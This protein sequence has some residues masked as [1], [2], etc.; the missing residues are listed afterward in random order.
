MKYKVGDRV[1]ILSAPGGLDN[2][3]DIFT[4][5]YIDDGM[6]PYK[7]EN[8]GYDEDEIELVESAPA[9]SEPS[10][11]ECAHITKTIWSDGVEIDHEGNITINGE[12]KSRPEWE[13][14]S[15]LIRRVLS[16]KRDQQ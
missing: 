15:K 2:V 1:R 6:Y 13:A 11:P 7:S 4:I 3:G 8:G 9:E 10:K 12:T 14:Q 16:R 5:K